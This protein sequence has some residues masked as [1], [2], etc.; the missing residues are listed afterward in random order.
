MKNKKW[1]GI[2]ALLILIAIYFFPFGQDLIMLWLTKLT[3]SQVTAWT[4]MYAGSFMLLGLGLIIGGVKALGVKQLSG[5]FKYI[6]RNPAVVITLMVAA[7]LIFI[8]VAK[9]IA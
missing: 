9:Y 2:G 8:T 7:F 4:F 1:A 6:K 5:I 3:G